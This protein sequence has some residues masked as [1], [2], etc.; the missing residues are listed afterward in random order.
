MNDFAQL[1]LDDTTLSELSGAAS[2][3]SSSSSTDSDAAADGHA[4]KK[5]RRNKDAK[6]GAAADDGT[7]ESKTTGTSDKKASYQ[8]RLFTQLAAVLRAPVSTSNITTATGSVD[9]SSATNIPQAYVRACLPILFE[10]F[11]SGYRTFLAIRQREANDRID[12]SEWTAVALQQHAARQRRAAQIQADVEFGC[13][14]RFHA[15]DWLGS[16]GTIGSSA[17]AGATESKSKSKSKS[18]ASTVTAAASDDSEL[19]S[20]LETC[21]ALYERLDRFHVYRINQPNGVEKFAVL[22]AQL[23]QVLAFAAQ[24]ISN[25]SASI[26]AG[27]CA[28][29]EHLLVL[30]ESLLDGLLPRVWL[31]I[32]QSLQQQQQSTSNSSAISSGHS[33]GAAV[34]QLTVV[35]A[36]TFAK[37]RQFG[38]ILLTYS[39]VR[40][41]F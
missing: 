24:P 22:R 20:R 26:A 1:L 2:T 10:A 25:A 3:A 11:L 7:D 23:E 13:F 40:L 6:D 5:R 19:G 15:L 41:L 14:V 29:I 16:T 4:N 38:M 35:L 33:A 21:G 9:S 31:F 30:N 32:W 8:H 39:P 12:D 18:S 28:C 37:L 17:A 36:H 34:R 27:I